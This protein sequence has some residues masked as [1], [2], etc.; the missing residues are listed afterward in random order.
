MEKM[1]SARCVVAM[2]SARQMAVEDTS[3]TAQLSL[4]VLIASSV[5]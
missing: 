3:A 2:A 1:A 5:S 4:T